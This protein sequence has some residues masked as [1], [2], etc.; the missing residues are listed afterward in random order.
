MNLTVPDE[1]KGRGKQSIVL[2]FQVKLGLIAL[3]PVKWEFGQLT[4]SL[5]FHCPVLAE[6]IG[7]DG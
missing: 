7:L 1:F 3:K 4:T 2:V 5:L 6:D